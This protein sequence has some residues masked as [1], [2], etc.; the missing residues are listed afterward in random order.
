MPKR[1]KVSW[2]RM[3]EILDLSEPENVLDIKTER[4]LYDDFFGCGR[5]SSSASKFLLST[6]EVIELDNLGIDWEDDNVVC[7]CAKKEVY[8]GVYMVG[9]F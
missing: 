7:L 8:P 2:E 5:H 1:I 6:N 3:L 9:E 4:E